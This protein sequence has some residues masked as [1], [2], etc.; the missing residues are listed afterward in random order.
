[1]FGDHHGNPIADVYSVDVQPEVSQSQLTQL[2]W[3]SISES[4]YF[5]SLPISDTTF[6]FL[7]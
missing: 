4:L 5:K 3:P 1:M 7:I 6:V 2:Q